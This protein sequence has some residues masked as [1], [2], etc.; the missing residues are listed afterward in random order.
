MDNENE[1]TADQIDHELIGR[2]VSFVQYAGGEAKTGTVR[3]AIR[4]VAGA[5]YLIIVTDDG[6]EVQVSE[7]AIKGIQ[8][9]EEPASMDQ[10]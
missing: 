1:M 2:K 3:T 7:M 9:N 8:F 6:D 10:E 4:D 5:V